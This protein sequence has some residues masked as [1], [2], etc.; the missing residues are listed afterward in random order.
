MPNFSVLD[1]TNNTG[2]TLTDGTPGAVRISNNALQPLTNPYVANTPDNVSV[3]A[4]VANVY[5]KTGAGN[6]FLDVHF[7]NGGNILDGGA[8]VNT[9]IGGSGNDGFEI[10]GNNLNVPAFD[11]IYGFHPGDVATI[12]GVAPGSLNLTENP[13]SGLILNSK[14]AAGVGLGMQI[15]EYGVGSAPTTQ[16]HVASGVDPT[17]G[18]YLKIWVT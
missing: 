13:Q 1:I 10:L 7:L 9:L 18:N 2:P 12:Y 3:T 4:L 6:D 17:Y 15:F 11:V 5:V 16:F 14:N 8:G